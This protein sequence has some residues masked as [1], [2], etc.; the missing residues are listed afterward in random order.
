MPQMN[1]AEAEALLLLDGSP[2]VSF[3]ITPQTEAAEERPT[4]RVQV[5][6]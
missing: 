4:L 3:R 1:L 5:L 2:R 6:P